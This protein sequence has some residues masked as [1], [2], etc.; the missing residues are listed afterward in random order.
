MRRAGKKPRRRHSE[1]PEKNNEL[2]FCIAARGGRAAVRGSA[3]AIPARG[4]SGF[5]PRAAALCSPGYRSAA[6]ARWALPASAGTRG[7]E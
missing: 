3:G 5:A 4:R 6:P 1:L 7:R 2:C